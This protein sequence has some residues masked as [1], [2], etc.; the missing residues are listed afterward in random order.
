MTRSGTVEECSVR[1][2]ERAVKKSIVSDKPAGKAVLSCITLQSLRH[3]AGWTLMAI[4]GDVGSGWTLERRSCALTKYDAE[5]SG[6]RSRPGCIQYALLLFVAIGR[7][8]EVVRRLKG[9]GSVG[10]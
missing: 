9:C 4:I 10:G 2:E 8:L 5:L 7:S 6:G 1:E 3:P